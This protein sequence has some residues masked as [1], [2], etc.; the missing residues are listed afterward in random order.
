MAHGKGGGHGGGAVPGR[1]ARITKDLEAKKAA[2][3]RGCKHRKRGIL[4]Y[5]LKW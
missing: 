1:N 3:P 2:N 5:V 4:T